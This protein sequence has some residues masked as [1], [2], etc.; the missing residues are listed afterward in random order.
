MNCNDGALY[1]APEGAYRPNAFG[2]HDMIGNASEWVQD[3]LETTLD[4]VPS[5]GSAHETSSC[6][7]R[8]IRGGSFGN[9]PQNLR[10]ANRNSNS[11][12]RRNFITGFRVART[13]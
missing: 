1:T 10:S 3:C 11:T 2:L 8:V 9:N 7:Q 6:A 5:D 13:L 4:S 12:T